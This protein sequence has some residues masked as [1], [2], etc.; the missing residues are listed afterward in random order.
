M[1]E[2]SSDVRSCDF[3]FSSRRRHTR[4]WRDWS[5]DVCSSDLQ[6]CLRTLAQ[7]GISLATITRI[8][9]DADQRAV[10]W[11][12]SHVPVTVRALAVDEIYAKD[13]H[14]ASL[15]VVDVHSG[16]VWASEGPVPVDS[17]SWTLVLWELQDRG[18]R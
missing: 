10:D 12:A 7:Q 2:C 17:D 11:M 3:F 16:A 13:R 1:H 5:S 6:T 8:L 18:L 9:H 4:Y 14:G 15:N